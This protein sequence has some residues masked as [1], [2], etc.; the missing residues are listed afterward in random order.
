MIDIRWAMR[1]VETTEEQARANA[2]SQQVVF[3]NISKT[4][5]D[6]QKVREEVRRMWDETLTGKIDLFDP[7]TGTTRYLENDQHQSYYWLNRGTGRIVG[8]STSEP[9]NGIGN[10]DLQNML[11]R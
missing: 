6:R 2:A 9:P 11:P 3:N 1:A 7:R 5:W 8:T 10:W 4:Y